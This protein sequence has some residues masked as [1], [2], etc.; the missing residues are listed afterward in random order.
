MPFTL[1]ANVDLLFAEAGDVPARIAA[2]ADA[3]FTAVE[4]WTSSDRDVEAIRRVAEGRGVEIT[5]MLAEP[6]TN[7]TWPD[8]DL[9]TYYAGVA[10]TVERARYL[11]CPRIVVSGGTGYMRTKRPVQLQQVADV[12]A[13]IL[14]RTEGSGI[15]FM[16]EPFNVRVD[17]PGALLDRTADAVQIVRS[18]DSERFGII[19]DLYHS[20]TEAE[21]PAQVFAEASDVIRYLQIADV[22]GRGEPGSGG[23]D[24]PALFSLIAS[25]GYSG[26]IGLEFYPTRDTAEAVRYIREVNA[27]V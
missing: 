6:R 13:E 11:G 23:I 15:T 21:D 14:R 1:S 19:Y 12:Y 17:H 4:F 25:T 26:Y 24:W 9:E 3:G 18:V 5:S 27:A 8:T 16:L 22:P 2:A 10:A 20:I 7:I